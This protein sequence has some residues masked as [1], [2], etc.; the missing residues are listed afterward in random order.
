MTDAEF[1]TLYASQRSRMVALTRR[2]GIPEMECEDVVQQA[3]MR[4]LRCE[5]EQYYAGLVKTLV[6]RA[7]IDWLRGNINRMHRVICIDDI[8]QNG[9]PDMLDKFDMVL[10]VKG[11]TDMERAVFIMLLNGDSCSEIG[12]VLCRSK[13]YARQIRKTI[14]GKIVS[15]CGQ[16]Q[17]LL[18]FSKQQH[19]QAVTGE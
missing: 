9:K 1:T 14:L 16:N 5:Y 13:E 8:D 12:A 2:M 10:S 17:E 3:F 15:Q 18:R 19:Q 6:I 11:L 7:S 4:L